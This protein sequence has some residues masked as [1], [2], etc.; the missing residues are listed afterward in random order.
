MRLLI[1]LALLAPLVASEALTVVYPAPASAD[2][3]RFEDLKALLSAALEATSDEG[4]YQT[5]P[6]STMHSEAR[7][8][9]AVQGG[10]E[11]NLIWTSTSSAKEE[12]LRPIRI[13]LRKGLLGFRACLI[14]ADRQGAFR[15]VRS[16]T[17]LAQLHVVQGQGWGDIEVFR[18]NRL[19]VV[20]GPSYES[21]FT[22]ITD[23]RADYFSRGV[24]EIGPELAARSAA[25]PEL[26]IES[27]LLLFYPWPYYFFTAQNNEALAAR[28]ERGLRA[29]I[30][31]GS[32]NHIVRSHHAAS[33]SEL[34]MAKRRVLRLRNP[35]LPAATPV[36][37]AR[38]WYR[39]GEWSQ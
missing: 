22:M 10:T 20:V 13:P 9:E 5:Q 36:N 2:D 27:D 25:L 15:G 16:L 28:I 1:L 35:L 24:T 32:F 38:L 39:P 19:P 4:P 18:A 11:L 8:I 31:D 12:V 26:A 21:L 17:D 7:Y 33:I 23:G 14:R 29:M 30:A 37:D 3:K 34:N 6:A